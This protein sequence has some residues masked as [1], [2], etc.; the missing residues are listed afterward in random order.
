[1]TERDSRKKVVLVLLEGNEAKAKACL[2][3]LK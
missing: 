3:E 2:I 1:L